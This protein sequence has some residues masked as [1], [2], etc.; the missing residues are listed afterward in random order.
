[1]VI[2][3]LHSNGNPK[4]DSLG[5]FPSTPQSPNDRPP[6]NRVFSSHLEYKK[7]SLG[8]VIIAQYLAFS[9]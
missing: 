7:H 2:V 4:T 5:L 1:M 8:S 6:H 3:S 9:K